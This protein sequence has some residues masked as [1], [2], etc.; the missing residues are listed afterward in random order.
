MIPWIIIFHEQQLHLDY[1]LKIVIA[2]V[3][4]IVKYHNIEINI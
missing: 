2:D 4:G 3:N 1:D